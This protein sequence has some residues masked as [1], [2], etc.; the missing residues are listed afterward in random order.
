MA[1]IGEVQHPT[2]SS[3]EEEEEEEV[4]HKLLHDPQKWSKL[5]KYRILFL[6][7]LPAFL[8]PLSNT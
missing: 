6:I 5:K 2:S 1:D 3:E 4:A 7:A 8:T